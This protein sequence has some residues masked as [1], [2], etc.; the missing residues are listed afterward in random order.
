MRRGYFLVSQS[1]KILLANIKTKNFLFAQLPSID[2]P[3]W[4]LTNPLANS[5]FLIKLLYNCCIYPATYGNAPHFDHMQS[6]PCIPNK[7]SNSLLCN[8]L[9]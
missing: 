5:D 3:V 9:V 6:N 4:I 2:V 7:S 8:N 1:R